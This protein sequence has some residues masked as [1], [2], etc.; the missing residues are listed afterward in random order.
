MRIMCK[1]PRTRRGIRLVLLAGAL[2]VAVRMPADAACAPRDRWSADELGVLASMRLNRLPAAPADPS[3]A[4]ESHPAAAAFGKRLFHDT[5]F[6]GNQA[7][8][9]ASCHAPDRRFQDGLP[10]GHGVGIG[11]RRSMPIVGTAHSPWLFWDG[12]KDSLWAQALGPLEDAAEHGGNRTRH[13]QLLREHYKQE[14]E[15]VFGAMPDLPTLPN[16]AGPL[17]SPIEKAAWA[18]MAPA[19]RDAVNRVFVGMGKAIAAYEKTLAYGESRFDRYAQAAIDGDAR[20][21]QLL[22]AQEVS[23]LRLFI[24][25]GQCVTCHNGPLLSDH[26]FHNTGVPPRDPLQP[27]PGRAAAIDKVRHDEFSCLGRFSDAKVEQCREL[28]FMV[29]EAAG[30]KAAFKTPSLRNVAL[31]PPYMHAGQFA[32]L[33]EVIGHYVKAPPA[34]VGHTELHHGGAGHAERKPIRLSG[35]EIQ[36]LASFLASLSGPITEAAGR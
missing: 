32:S 27:D 26:H 8:S 18:T 15:S 10:L 2:T 20:S 19:T 12:R 11:A 4:V 5:R 14:Y 6:S 31:R 22:S 17:S 3:N 21:G 35:Q 13:V 25:K 7:V 28:R 36:D 24:G 30:L 29:T 1:S 16:D 34:V 33:E 9:C 23:G